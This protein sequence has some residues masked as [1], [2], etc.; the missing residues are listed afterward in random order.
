LLWAPVDLR[1]GGAPTRGYSRPGRI[2]LRHSNKRRCVLQKRRSAS[3]RRASRRIETRSCLPRVCR[4]VEQPRR[5]GR[6]SSIPGHAAVSCHSRRKEGKNHGRCPRPRHRP[7]RESCH[8]RNPLP[9][10][11]GR[12]E[13]PAEVC[14]GVEQ[15]RRAERGSSI[16]GH[17]AVGCRSRMKGGKNHG[18]HPRPL[19]RPRRERCHVRNPLPPGKGRGEEPAAGSFHNNAKE[20]QNGGLPGSPEAAQPRICTAGCWE[21]RTRRRTPFALRRLPRLPPFPRPL[22]LPWKVPASTYDVIARSRKGR[23]KQRRWP[24]SCLR[25][26]PHPASELGER[27]HQRKARGRSSGRRGLLPGRR[28]PSSA[29]PVLPPLRCSPLFPSVPPDLC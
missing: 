22:L 24:L 20:K 4:G 7:R 15:P 14:R 11:K 2:P 9:P 19:H 26:R 13:E 29:P 27:G 3:S 28:A 5:A 18:C 25:G 1:S 21:R 17:A 8:V 16:P 12:G 6:G 10:G 23:E